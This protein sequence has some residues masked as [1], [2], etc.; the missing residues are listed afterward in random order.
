LFGALYLAAALLLGAVFCG[1][2]LRLW[3]RPN[4]AAALRLYLS[5]LAYLALLFIAMA[6]D[7]V[8]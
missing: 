6:A 5:S 3:A 1:L 7:R 2:A 4:R 8:L